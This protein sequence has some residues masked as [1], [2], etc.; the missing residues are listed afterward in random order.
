MRPPRSWIFAGRAA[1]L[2]CG[3]AA[4]A[5]GWE[6]WGGKIEEGKIVTG[7]Q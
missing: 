7:D 6:G 3:G 2:E 4:A 5:L 1:A